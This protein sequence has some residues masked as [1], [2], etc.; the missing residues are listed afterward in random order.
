MIEKLQKFIVRMSKIAIYAVIMC[1]S[2][3]MAFA[4]E[5]EAQRKMLNEI[6]I[7]LEAKEVELIDL[8]KEVERSTNF[9]FAF[10]KEDIKGKL[11]SLKETDWMMNELLK[12]L[13]IQGEL[14]FRRV[15]ESINIREVKRKGNLP[16]VYEQVD[17]QQT[18]SGKITDENGEGLPGATVQEQGTSNGTITD[19]NG[20]YSISVPESA[21]LTVS[22][23]GFKSQDLSINGRSVIDIELSPDLEALDEVVVVG[24]GT[25]QKRK[26]TGAVSSVNMKGLEDQSNQDLGEALRGKVSGV[27]VVTHDGSPGSAPTIQIRGLNSITAGQTPLL[28]IDGVPMEDMMDLSVVNPQNIESIEILKDASASSIYG[29]RAS[30]GV[31]LVTTKGSKAGAL[32]FNVS[33][34]ASVQQLPRKVPMMNAEQ[35]INF[36]KAASQNAWVYNVGGDP[37]APNTVAARG[38]IKYTWPQEWDDPNVVANWPTTDW[39][40]ET[41]EDAP[42]HEINMSASGGTDKVR[43]NISGNFLDQ[44]GIID[45]GNNFKRFFLQGKIDADVNDWFRMGVNINSRYTQNTDVPA[46]WVYAQHGVEMPPIYPSITEQGYAGNAVEIVN[47]SRYPSTTPSMDNYDGVYF[48]SNASPYGFDNDSDDRSSIKTQGTL[49]AEIQLA[50]GL[51]FRT[52]YMQDQSRGDNSVYNA[53][54][55]NSSFRTAAGNMNRN[56]S[57]TSHWFLNNRVNFN[58]SFGSDHEIDI[59]AGAEAQKT[60]NTGFSARS[61]GFENDLTPFLS[62]AQVPTRNGDS[63]VVTTY[64]S[65][66]ARANYILKDR[67]II[68]GSIRYDASSRFGSNNKWGSFPSLGV[69]WIVSEES[70]M[71]GVSLVDNLKFRA[72]YGL[73]G[74]NNFGDYI[75]IPSLSQG[76]TVIGGTLNTYFNKSSLPNPDLRWEKTGMLNVGFDVSMLESRLGLTIDLYQSRTDDLLLNLPISSLTGFTSLLQNVGSVR[77]RGFEFAINTVNVTTNNF[78]W[79]TNFNFSMNRGQALDLGGEEFLRPFGQS[80]F[81]VRVYKDG[82]RLF[83]YFAYD[84]IG[85]YRD[86]AD[87]D[88]SPSYAGAEPGDAK[89]RDVDGD[90]EIDTDDRTVLGTM[91]PDFTWNMSNGVSYKGFDFNVLLTAVQGGQ[92]VNRFRRRVQWWHG[93][94]NLITDMTT[95]WSEENPDSY[96]FKPSVDVTSFNRNASSYWLEDASFVKIQNI[97]LGYSF[98][99]SLLEK[100]QLSSLRVYVSAERL[101]SFDNFIGHDPEQGRAGDKHFQRGFS[102]SEYAIPRVITGGINIRL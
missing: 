88:N 53:V 19:I 14:S 15:N 46:G 26:L 86:Q 41:Y 48:N 3:S 33:Y 61:D 85:T 96:R 34:E 95:A 87:I 89:Y 11:I 4:T 94:R 22:F 9:V 64:R 81:D 69:G 21:I 55:R 8:I 42:M 67:Y 78:Q 47:D 35:Y 77:N 102:H 62:V 56:W 91:M 49:W 6:S 50:E 99:K 92:K 2:L 71:Q 29:S 13:S 24:Y 63:K 101:F 54:D 74:N 18:V 82:D 45:N 51:T 65:Y 58:R 16:D 25:M 7:H 36:A 60:T 20:A 100:I 70:F 5:G 30:A 80:G 12:E 27:Q 66:F 40:E 59:V 97:T 10:S 90:G 73:T 31:V 32:T 43:Y 72:S 76:T 93:G 75:W 38:N 44:D 68:N 98:S 23:V 39:Q 28:V 79:N 84:Y 57:N 52:T 37:N 17:A 83:E 1:Y